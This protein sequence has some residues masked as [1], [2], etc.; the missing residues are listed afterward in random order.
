M[1]Y[2][3]LIRSLWGIILSFFLGNGLWAQT[4]TV[5][6][7]VY[8]RGSLELLPYINV[9]EE[10]SGMSVF[11]NEYGFYVMQIPYADT[12]TV[13]FSGYGYAY[14]TLRMPLRVKRAGA[15]ASLPFGGGRKAGTAA[16][17]GQWV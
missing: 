10:K 12:I 1:K 7:Y 4:V 9:Y 6:G 14:D 11:S 15:V 17:A 16:L 5:S 8:E 13:V 2:K 3:N